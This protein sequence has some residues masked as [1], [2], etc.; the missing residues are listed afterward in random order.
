MDTYLEPKSGVDVV[1]GSLLII[2]MSQIHSPK[3]RPAASTIIATYN[4]FFQ[5]PRILR[6]V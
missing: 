1:T 5:N 6:P 4:T 2:Y 3:T